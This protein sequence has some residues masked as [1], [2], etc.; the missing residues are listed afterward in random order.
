M[1]FLFREATTPDITSC[2]GLCHAQA[3]VLP[4]MHAQALLGA[5]AQ[6]LRSL[7][8]HAHVAAACWCGRVSARIEALLSMFRYMSYDNSP[9]RGV[10]REYIP[11]DATI[12][13]VRLSFLTRHCELQI[14]TRFSCVTTSGAQSVPK[15]VQ[16]ANPCVPCSMHQHSKESVQVSRG[17]S[18]SARQPESIQ[19][20]SCPVL[21]PQKLL[22]VQVGVG[23]SENP[24]RDG[25]GR[26]PPDPE[27][28]QLRRR[29]E[30]WLFGSCP[31]YPS[32]YV[33]HLPSAA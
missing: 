24:A 12:L 22:S 6:L 2:L 19:I 15:I 21:S 14:V 4:T 20:W 1:S 5:A 16:D 33:P 3:R 25:G 26:L 29:G 30:I 23:T 13:Q 8:Q 7:Q 27:H 17:A 32:L 11:F 18:C 10:L 31:S 9:L 28:G